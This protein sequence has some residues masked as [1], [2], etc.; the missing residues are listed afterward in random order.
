VI[1][2]APHVARASRLPSLLQKHST[3]AVTAAHW[4]QSFCRHSIALGIS[5]LGDLPVAAPNTFWRLAT[6][7]VLLLASTLFNSL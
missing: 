1:I 4:R 2:L 5:K 3:K 7:F 6:A